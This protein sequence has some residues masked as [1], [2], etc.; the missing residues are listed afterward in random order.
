MSQ[1]LILNLNFNLFK[2]DGE[3]FKLSDIDSWIKFK[4]LF[5]HFISE[6]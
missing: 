3:K 2:Q 1:K 4:K 6:S 5:Q